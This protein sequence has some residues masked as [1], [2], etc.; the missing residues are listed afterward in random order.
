[1]ALFGIL[2]LNP[3]FLLKRL[4]FGRR[5]VQAQTRALARAVLIE[6]RAAALRVLLR[7]PALAARGPLL[8]S[9][10]RETENAFRL[11]VSPQ[12]VGTLWKLEGDDGQRFAGL[13]L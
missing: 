9:F 8:E 13:L 10:E 1:G 6:S 3:A 11:H 7:A 4:G 12:L 2:P 5:A